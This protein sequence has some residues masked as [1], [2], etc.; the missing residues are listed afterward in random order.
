MLAVYLADPA[1]PRLD[2]NSSTTA[3]YQQLFDSFARREVLKDPDVS[4]N[5]PDFE[6]LVLDH[7]ER[8]SVAALAMFNRGV[9]FVTDIDL[10][11]DISSLQ[12]T[13]T[14]PAD[15]VELGQRLIG[16]FFFVHSAE[17]TLVKRSV[18]VEGVVR[19]TYEFLHATF[20][21]YFVAQRVV[22]TLRSMAAAGGGRAAAP[23]DD[24]LAAI[25]SHQP[26]AGRDSVLQ[27]LM[28]LFGSLPVACQGDVVALLPA[29]LARYRQRRSSGGYAGYQPTQPDLPR[30]LATYSANLVMLQVAFSRV[31][32]TDVG[33][34]ALFTG[35]LA[36]AEREWRSIVCLWRA[37]L[38]AEGWHA[39]VAG[40]ELN[41]GRLS[42]RAGSIDLRPEFDEF[43]FARLMGNPASA[44]QVRYG[45]A[46]RDG[47]VL[48]DEDWVTTMLSWIVPARAG[49]AAEV[50]LPRPVDVS[51]DDRADVATAM[52]L[53]LRNWRGASTELPGI[54]EAY[55]NLTLAS[56][57]DSYALALNVSHHPDLLRSL[58]RLQ[59]ARLYSNG[60]RRVVLMLLQGRSDGQMAGG[61]LDGS[62]NRLVR[63]LAPGL[64][65]EPRGSS[66]IAELVKVL[67]GTG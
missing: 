42:L 51:V 6:S 66:D 62:L 43:Y 37:G 45:A 25:L 33:L 67:R 11:L 18:D 52:G 1:S 28:E 32:A 55:L 3:L 27:F 57:V 46:I 65:G 16:E 49:L 60:S 48:R 14:A 21:E 38:E 50:V 17:V 23:E 47:S 22:D 39:M 35:D 4:P 24:F 31:L 58:P 64:P 40:L 7:L 44:D 10:G 15:A 30:E 8:L 12:E 13:G 54:I 59:D 26:L 9:Q 19:R 20:G 36:D 53:L 29:V 5:Q 61:P 2:E 56:E 41:E 34:E 63:E